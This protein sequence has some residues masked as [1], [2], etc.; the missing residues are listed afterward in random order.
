MSEGQVVVVEAGTQNRLAQHIT[1]GAHTWVADEPAGIGDDTGPTPYDLLLSALGACT[2]MTLRMYADRRGWPLERIRV[3][4]RH[5]RHHADDGLNCEASATGL[6]HIERLIELDGDLDDEQR[7]RL[8]AIAERCP[9]HRTL[10]SDKHI[11]TNLVASPA[12]DDSP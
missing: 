1:A 9:V 7:S 8:L 10:V 11:V 2:S 4:L 6:E 5:D 12:A 3:T